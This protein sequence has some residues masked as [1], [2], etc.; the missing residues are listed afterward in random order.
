MVVPER[1]SRMPASF[2]VTSD[3]YNG[4]GSLMVWGGISM[5]G[6]TDL[7]LLQQGSM[8]AQRYRD[9][10]LDVHTSDPMQ[11]LSAM[12]SSY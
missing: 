8:M 7:L 1:G 3:R 5:A 6:R 4:G 2:T 10:V 12:T 9:E 11:E